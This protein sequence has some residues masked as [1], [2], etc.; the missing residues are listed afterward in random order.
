M[1]SKVKTKSAQHFS[2]AGRSRC[3]IVPSPNCKAKIS[4]LNGEE[5]LH[6][7]VGITIYPYFHRG[8]GTF[9]P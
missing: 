9:G 5:M 7:K 8:K 3:L 2:A 6:G 1:S 4:T